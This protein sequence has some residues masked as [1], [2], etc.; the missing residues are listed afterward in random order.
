[1]WWPK[2]YT[3][4]IS[5]ASWNQKQM[6]L[7]SFFHINFILP[8]ISLKATSSVDTCNVKSCRWIGLQMMTTVM[9]HSMDQVAL[10]PA[11]LARTERQLLG[12]VLSSNSQSV[13]VWLFFSFLPY[14]DSQRELTY[15][16]DK[17]L[18]II[19]KTA[20]QW[21]QN[22]NQSLRQGKIWIEFLNGER[23][24]LLVLRSLAV[25]SLR[26]WKT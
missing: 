9:P 23:R 4:M 12:E 18:F 7:R 6:F 25:D 22:I 15:R 26:Q 20:A 5:P 3:T 21:L 16:L 8:E 14:I 17:S 10:Y 19:P 13:L 24:K 1:M 11:R 2:S